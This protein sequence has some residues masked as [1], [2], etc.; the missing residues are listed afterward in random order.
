MRAA[1]R[2]AVA[3]LMALERA[4]EEG[5]WD[6]F[7]EL[8]DRESWAMEVLSEDGGYGGATAPS[9]E[10]QAVHSKGDTDS[11]YGDIF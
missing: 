7:Y 1:E 8:V 2:E 4:K 3:Y 6:D 10:M 9:V 5:R 11:E